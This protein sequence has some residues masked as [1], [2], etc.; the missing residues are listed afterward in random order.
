M[1]VFV[2]TNPGPGSRFGQILVMI[3]SGHQKTKPVPADIAVEKE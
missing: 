1:I 2:K 3:R